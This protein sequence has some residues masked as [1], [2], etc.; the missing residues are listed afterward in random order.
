MTFP[1]ACLPVHDCCAD[2]GRLVEG[3][4]VVSTNN[5]QT[6]YLGGLAS[7]VSKT[8]WFGMGSR[9]AA[10]RATILQRVPSSSNSAETSSCRLDGGSPRQQRQLKQAVSAATKGFKRSAGW[11]SSS[12]PARRWL[13]DLYSIAEST[14]WGHYVGASVKLRAGMSLS[15]FPN[16]LYTG[17]LYQVLIR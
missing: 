10:R 9:T 12:Q 14:T 3:V 1:L 6:E 7:R 11:K 5:V 15:G 16:W 13:G 17:G 4:R 8:Y 2:N